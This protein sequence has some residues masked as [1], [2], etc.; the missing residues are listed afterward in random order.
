[1]ANVNMKLTYNLQSEV[2]ELDGYVGLDT[3]A[4]VVAASTVFPN[5]TVAKTT[6]GV[7]TITLANPFPKI[8]FVGAHWAANAAASGLR[9]EVGPVTVGATTSVVIRTTNAAGAATDTGVAGGF[10]VQI[11]VKNTSVVN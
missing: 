11:K 4:A 1:M 2:C 10:W 9:C 8:V 7:Y 3:S 6:T 5:A